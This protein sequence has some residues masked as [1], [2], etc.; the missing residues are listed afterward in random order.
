MTAHR[1]NRRS[2]GYAHLQGEAEPASLLVRNE[3]DK[4]VKQ[5]RDD[6]RIKIDKSKEARQAG[7]ELRKG[8]PI[9][10]PRRHLPH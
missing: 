5:S 4:E 10:F 2:A 8:K 7:Q 6:W 1:N 9:A 3:K